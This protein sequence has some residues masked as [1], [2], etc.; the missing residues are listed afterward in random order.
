[1]L[2]L[3]P[4][5]YTIQ[6]TNVLRA[7]IASK[8]SSE[9]W[10]TSKHGSCYCCASRLYKSTSACLLSSYNILHFLIIPYKKQ[11]RRTT[12]PRVLFWSRK[13]L[14]AFPWPDLLS[15]LPFK[16]L[17]KELSATTMTRQPHFARKLELVADDALL[18]LSLSRGY[19]KLTLQQ[20]LVIKHTPAKINGQNCFGSNVTD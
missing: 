6:E 7:S 18:S 13:F 11:I 1:M 17:T 20:T 2:P 10:R 4:K 14:C 3:Y 5:T 12:C 8:T 19:E 15:L 9:T 16:N